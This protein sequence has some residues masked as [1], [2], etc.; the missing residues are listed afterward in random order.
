MQKSK[1]FILLIIASLS[2]SASF[3]LWP[4]ELSYSF[5]LELGIAALDKEDYDEALRYFTLA[6]TVNPSESNQTYY[7]MFS[8]FLQYC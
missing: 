1:I 2:F 7:S 3:S 4:Q 6:Q 8:F 5:L